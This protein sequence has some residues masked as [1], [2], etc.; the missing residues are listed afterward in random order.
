MMIMM[1]RVNS[2]DMMY[3][4][5]I[6]TVG[7]GVFGTIIG[8]AVVFID[9]M[10]KFGSW[11]ISFLAVDRIQFLWF[12]SLTCT[13]TVVIGVIGIIVLTA[14]RRHPAGSDARSQMLKKARRL[15]VVRCAWVFVF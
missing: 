12:L 15:R 8:L 9:I 10:L 5:R 11:G 14:I 3:L 6:F 2:R 4:K 1:I 13:M 7:F